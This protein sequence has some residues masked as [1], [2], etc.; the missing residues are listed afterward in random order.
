[1]G[2]LV[3][4]KDKIEAVICRKSRNGKISYKGKKY[5]LEIKETTSLHSGLS[6]K[7]TIIRI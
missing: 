5:P 1:M 3:M 4:N 7:S 6:H 2:I